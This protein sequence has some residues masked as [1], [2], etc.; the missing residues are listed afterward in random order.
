MASKTDFGG[1]KSKRAGI[2][3]SKQGAIGYVQI[4]YTLKL[5]QYKLRGMPWQLFIIF[6]VIKLGFSFVRDLQLNN[7]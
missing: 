5:G 2:L 7:V 1:T 3:A 6:L 4:V